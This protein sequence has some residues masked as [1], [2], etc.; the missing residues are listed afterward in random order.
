[1]GKQAITPESIREGLPD[2]LGFLRS[3]EAGL[4]DSVDAD[5]LDLLQGALSNPLKL[6]MLARTVAAGEAA[7]S[8]PQPRA[9][10]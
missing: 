7:L 6:A 8:A 10:V 3:L 5:L 1:M 2:L 4:P 9:R